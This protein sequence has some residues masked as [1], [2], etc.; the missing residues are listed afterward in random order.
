MFIGMAPVR[1]LLAGKLTILAAAALVGTFFGGSSEASAAL[2]CREPAG[3][4][5]LPDPPPAGLHLPLRRPPLCRPDSSDPEC[6]AQTPV[7]GNLPILPAPRQAPPITMAR[8]DQLS[9]A[10]GARY[11]FPRVDLS[12]EHPGFARAIERPPRG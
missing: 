4:F 3:L 8:A 1:S 6:S 7:G 12:R 2:L 10:S 9:P 5:S 11:S